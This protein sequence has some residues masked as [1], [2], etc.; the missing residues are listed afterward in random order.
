MILGMNHHLP[1]I[2]A[3]ALLVLF[4]WLAWSE[5]RKPD[6]PPR[7]D[8]ALMED[9]ED[10]N[11]PVEATGGY[12]NPG[13]VFTWILLASVTT[14]FVVLKWIVPTVG[15]FVADTFFFSTEKIEETPTHHAL[16][17]VAQG[18]YDEA[19][20]V[21]EK[22]ITKNP[23]DRF[24]VM[25]LSRLNMDKLGDI[26]AGVAV[27]EQAVTRDWPP[28]DHGFLLVKLAG[29]HY[30]CRSDAARARELLKLVQSKYPGSG[31]ASSAYHKLN[32]IDEAEFFARRLP[33]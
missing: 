27:L 6:Q 8:S 14:G 26:E 32:E 28:E 3:A 1:R 29:L 18:Q 9:R 21:F 23:Q 2:L 4:V 5:N 33:A 15:Q 20:A 22:I 30:S 7:S 10:I 17:L 13:V 12:R 31:C 25:E 19:V 24:A 11:A 16:S